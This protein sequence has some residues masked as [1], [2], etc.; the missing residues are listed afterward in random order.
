MIFYSIPTNELN[1]TIMNAK[2]VIG[3]FIAGAAL[4]AAAGLLFAPSSGQRSWRRLV[5]GSEK[6]KKT[7]A[8]YV[9]DSIEGLRLKINDK[10][11]QVALKSKDTVNHA[12]ERVKI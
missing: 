4:G 3:G 12:S 9:D 5:K 10:I 1:D 8:N 11:D 7:L 2:N 6:L